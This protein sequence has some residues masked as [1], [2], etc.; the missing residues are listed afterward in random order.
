VKLLLTFLSSDFKSEK[1]RKSQKSQN[2]SENS[3]KNS[4]NSEKNSEMTS[5]DLIHISWLKISQK[6]TQK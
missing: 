4:E 2:N 1:V 3:E 5:H 6:R